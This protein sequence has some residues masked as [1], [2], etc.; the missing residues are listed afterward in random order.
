M[1][2]MIMIMMMLIKMVMLVM[3]KQDL[4]RHCLTSLFCIHV[5]LYFNLNFVFSF[6]P[7]GEQGSLCR[8]PTGRRQSSWRMGKEMMRK[9]EEEGEEKGEEEEEMGNE[10]MRKE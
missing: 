2:V 4:T 7:R 1:I 3:M 6:L 9:E 8:M 5:Y 10:M